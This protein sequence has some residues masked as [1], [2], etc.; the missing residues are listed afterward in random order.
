MTSFTQIRAQALAL[1]DLLPPERLT[2]VVQ[3]LEFL[4]EPSGQTIS[5]Q[6]ATLLELQLE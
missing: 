1:I 4:A 6:E 2:A 3:L 5:S